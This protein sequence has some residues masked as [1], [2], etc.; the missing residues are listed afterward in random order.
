MK[1]ICQIDQT[2]RVEFSKY[3][4]GVARFLLTTNNPSQL[5]Q[6]LRSFNLPILLYEL[7]FVLS[8]KGC[9]HATE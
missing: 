4:E 9:Q 3:E 8:R 1:A 7:T 2:H 6:L 5:D